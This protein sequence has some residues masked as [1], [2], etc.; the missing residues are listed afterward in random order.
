[1]CQIKF[2]THKTREQIMVTY[3]FVRVLNQFMSHCMAALSFY[4]RTFQQSTCWM[5]QMLT[6]QLT[7]L[8]K[9]KTWSRLSQPNTRKSVPDL[10]TY[11]WSW[12]GVIAQSAQRLATGWTVWGS[13][14]GG[15][16]I[17]RICPD[18]PCG[19]PSLL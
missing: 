3:I 12:W 9:A 8:I 11:G 4:V 18:R 13:N 2:H 17:L 15:D 5:W 1:M 16:D 14:P 7:L 19:P 10:R 6:T